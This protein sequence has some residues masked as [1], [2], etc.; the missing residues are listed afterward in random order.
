M[1]IKIEAALIV[2]GLPVKVFYFMG[3]LIYTAG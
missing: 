3:R 2:D 1:Q